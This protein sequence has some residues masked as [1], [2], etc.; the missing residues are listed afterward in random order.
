MPPALAYTRQGF[1]RTW[2]TARQLRLFPQLLLFLVA[3]MVYNDGV[4]T[5]NAMT[6]SYATVTLG[7]TLSTIVLAFLVAQVPAFD[8]FFHLH[9]WRIPAVLKGDLADDASRL[10]RL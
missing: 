5:I 6:S 1:A 9:E 3:Y 4:Q 2:E 8:G 7:L 10:G